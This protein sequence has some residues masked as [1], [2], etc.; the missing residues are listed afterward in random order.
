MRFDGLWKHPDFLRLWAGQTVSVFGSLITHATLPFIAAL[1]LDASALQMAGLAAAGMA[2]SVLVAMHAGVW[3]DRLRRRPV[4]IAA[5]LLRAAIIITIPIAFWFDALHIAH[6]YVVAL[7]SG[8]LTIFF[9][10]AYQSYL[11]TLVSRDELLEGNSKLTASASVSEFAG[12]SVSGWLVQ[13]FNGPVALLI[14]AATF[15]GSAFSLGAIRSPE[16]PP[17]PAAE[18]TSVREEAVD[19]LRT[20]MRAPVLRALALTQAFAAFGFGVFAA[21]YTL[22]VT[23][24][25]GFEPALLG[26]IYGIGGISSLLGALFAQRA[27]RRWGVGPAMCAGVT[28]MGV[29]M[30]FIAAAPEAGVIGAVLLIAQQISGDGMYTVYD[31]NAVSLRQSMVDDRMLG[32]VNAFMRML[33]LA[34][35]L[36]GVLL[37]GVIGEFVGLRAAMTLSACFVITGGV[38]LIL[39][40]ARGIRSAPA[41]APLEPGS[42]LSLEAG[43]PQPPAYP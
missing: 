21:L 38:L 17:I 19:G 43:V 8:V 37:G 25:L 1:L 22:F 18:R 34:F 13:V 10:V 26:V 31:V 41:V 24:G 9:D 42:A 23:R 33:E 6:L 27:A 36:T 28:M 11:P 39:S 29:S 16:P 30:L 7:G 32:R 40:P 3:V 2:P 20:V 35:T 5:D 4:M 12:F 14:D 15:V